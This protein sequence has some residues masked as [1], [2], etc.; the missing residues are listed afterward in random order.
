LNWRYTFDKPAD[1]WYSP[2]FD[3]AAWKEGPGGFGTKGTPG[4]IVRT[5]WNT[6]DIWMR[7]VVTLD[8]INAKTWQLLVHH[9][10]DVE[11]YLNGVLAGSA[12]G[13]ISDYELMSL[14]PAGRAA[15]KPGKNII[16]IHCHQTGGGQYVDAGI[17]DAPGLEE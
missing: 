7:R 15:L 11:I 13:Y 9:D 14:T 10:E 12:S 8:A 2:D 16:A 6:P 5:V 17:V 1:S 3:A 4:S